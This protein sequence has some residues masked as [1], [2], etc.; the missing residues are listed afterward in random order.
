MS[1]A[2]DGSDHR[3]CC[4]LGGVPSS[5]LDWCRGEEVEEERL[6]SLPSYTSTIL[7]CF[8]KGLKSLPGPP[9]QVTVRP[10]DRSSALVFWDLPTKNPNSVELYR[11][12]W[13]MVGTNEAT[14]KSDTV[15]RKLVLK[16]LQ[17]GT[18]YELVVKAGNS[19][20]TSQLTHP[21]KFVTADNF[22]IATSPVTNNAGGAVGIVMAVIIVISLIVLILYIMKR[23]NLVLMA[24]KKPESPTVAFENPFYANRDQASNP[25]AGA[26]EEYNIHIS[27]SGS[28]HD[29][30]NSSHSGSS[31]GSP[32]PSTAQNSPGQDR[33]ELQVAEQSN[34]EGESPGLLAMLGQGRNG[35][36]RFK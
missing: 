1:C 14:N 34:T 17:P 29:E 33:S 21:L 4:S 36:T 30:L 20:G 10:L 2:S 26:G 16:G 32:Q 12:F 3:H 35:F 28:W 19:N 8:H 11:V 13:R 25:S 15:K 6:C 24:V 23:K 7:S 18:E 27:S 5:C 9:N 22:L 31:S